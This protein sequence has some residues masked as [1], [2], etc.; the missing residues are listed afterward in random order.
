MA[1]ILFDGDGPDDK[2]FKDVHV[3]YHTTHL[4]NPEIKNTKSSFLQKVNEQR[5]ASAENFKDCFEHMERE[6]AKYPDDTRFHA[7]FFSDG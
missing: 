1:D 5:V 7:V 4:D 2:K 3:A 6:V